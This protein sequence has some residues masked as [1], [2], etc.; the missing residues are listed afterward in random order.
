M[1]STVHSPAQQ[2]DTPRQVRSPSPHPRVQLSPGEKPNPFGIR[3]CDPQPLC[4][5]CSPHS[6]AHCSFSHSS[7]KSTFLICTYYSLCSCIRNVGCFLFRVSAQK[8]LM[9]SPDEIPSPSLSLSLPW[10]VVTSDHIGLIGLFTKNN[11]G[12]ALFYHPCALKCRDR[13]GS[14]LC[15]LDGWMEV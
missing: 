15:R 9:S 12:G 13:H 1:L 14:T 7:G 4:T 2:K 3:P 6:Q 8:S 10:L 11:E 5:P